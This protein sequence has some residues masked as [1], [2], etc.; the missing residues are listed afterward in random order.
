MRSACRREGTHSARV[1]DSGLAEPRSHGGV[2]FRGAMHFIQHG[3]GPY[4]QPLCE[5][6]RSFPSGIN[7][8]GRSEEGV[9]V[10]PLRG[11]SP[12]FDSFAEKEQLRFCL[13]AACSPSLS[14]EVCKNVTTRAYPCKMPAQ[15][16]VTRKGLVSRSPETTLFG[17]SLLL[18]N[19]PFESYAR[20]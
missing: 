17:M 8:Y 6:R 18:K 11:S 20:P 7:Q 16:H 5:M 10:A 14:A 19:I 9:E 2:H 1:R 3:E 12:T 15:T 13:C 4:S